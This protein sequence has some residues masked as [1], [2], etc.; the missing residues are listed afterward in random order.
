MGRRRTG[1]RRVQASSLVHPRLHVAL[2][3]AL[4]CGKKGE[5]VLTFAPS[6]GRDDDDW[7]VGLC[8][9]LAHALTRAHRNKRQSTL[10]RGVHLASAGGVG[11]GDRTAESGELDA[12]PQ[13]ARS[14]PDSREPEMVCRGVSTPYQ[15][16][17]AVLDQGA[18]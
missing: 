5:G 3:G 11:I 13:V 6:Q 12:A 8:S 17:L 14:L 16:R 18:R 2:Q 9:R 1:Q 7:F 10:G 15:G 4:G